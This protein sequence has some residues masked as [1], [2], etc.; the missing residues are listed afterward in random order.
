MGCLFAP[1]PLYRPQVHSSALWWWWWW[2]RW[3]LWWWWWRE[4]GA[5]VEQ[6]EEGPGHLLIGCLE[7][8]VTLC[9][10]TTVRGGWACFF[11]S[12]FF[13]AV[14]FNGCLKLQNTQADGCGSFCICKG[15][16]K[17]QTL[18]R[19]S[20][21]GGDGERRDSQEPK[22]GWYQH[23]RI[24]VGGGSR[25]AANHSVLTELSKVQWGGGGIGGGGGGGGPGK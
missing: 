16:G 17:R 13:I 6:G 21:Q 18:M 7:R 10:L 12:F 23:M 24:D 20:F 2:R 1:K 22:L 15:E 4:V 3:K 11:F 19:Y 5:G 25:S 8:R 14:R 9:L